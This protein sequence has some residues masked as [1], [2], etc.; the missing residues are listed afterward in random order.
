MPLSYGTTREKILQV[1]D[2]LTGRADVWY[3]ANQH[4]RLLN[5]KSK[6]LERDIYGRF[7]NEF[8]EA[9]RNYHEQREAKQAM[10]KN[11]QWKAQR[12]V[13]YIS[14]NRA[15]QLIPCLSREAFWEQLVNSI[16]PEVRTNMI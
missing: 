13:D 5:E 2:L 9:N 10:L 14:P 3:C 7:K 6:W 15:H 1:S 8:L 12:M 11:Y 16:Q 4:K